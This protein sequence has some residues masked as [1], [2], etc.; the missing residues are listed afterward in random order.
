LPH[1]LYKGRGFDITN[2][3]AQLSMKLSEKGTQSKKRRDTPR[4]C[5]GPARR[6]FRLRGS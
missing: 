5:R 3:S 4:Q 2:R 1:R 6:R